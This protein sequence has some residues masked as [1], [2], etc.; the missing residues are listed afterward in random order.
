MT[1]S[2]VWPAL[3]LAEWQDTYA[4]LHMWTQIVGKTRLDARADGKSL[5]AGR[6]VCHAARAH[7]LADAAR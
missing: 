2:S 5:V 4:T 3:P 6:A 1:A 7:H